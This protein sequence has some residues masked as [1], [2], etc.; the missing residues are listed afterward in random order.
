MKDIQAKGKEAT[1]KEQGEY[2]ALQVVNEMLARKIE[3]L[4]VDL[5]KS[6]ASTYQIEDGKIRLA[7]SSIKGVGENA[8]KAMQEARDDG[9]GAYISVDDL[10]R[11][12]GISCSVAASLQEVGALQG[13]PQSSQMSLF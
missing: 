6:D 11:R 13:I 2:T 9:E 3:F 10:Q 5:Y 7:F 12:A 1:A 8:A 4:P